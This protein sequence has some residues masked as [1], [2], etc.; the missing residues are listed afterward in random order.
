MGR[1]VSESD[2]VRFLRGGDAYLRPREAGV[3]METGTLYKGRFEFLPCL[4]E[5]V[6]E[7]M[8]RQ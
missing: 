4:T 3:Y 7:V 2:Q 5:S 1:S 8:L 6:Y